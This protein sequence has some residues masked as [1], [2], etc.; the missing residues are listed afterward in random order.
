MEKAQRWANERWLT[1]GILRDVGVTVSEIRI[2]FPV[3]GPDGEYA[4][5]VMR[6]FEGD[7]RYKYPYGI[8]FNHLLYGYYEQIDR[9]REHGFCITTEGMADAL[10][11]RRLGLPAVG[12]FSSVL[13]PIQQALLHKVVKRILIWGDGD[14]A[15]EGFASSKVFLNT[16]TGYMISGFVIDGYDPASYLAYT[17]GQLPPSVKRTI[18][19]CDEGY[20]K[21]DRN[22]GILTQIK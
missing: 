10:A 7:V 6:Y 18:K 16:Q 21:F 4:F 19:L 20:R 14:E 3:T 13:S 15:G 11:V 9:M 22:G 2:K 1:A 8:R 5:D 17:D 12:C